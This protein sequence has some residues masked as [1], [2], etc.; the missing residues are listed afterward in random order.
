MLKRFSLVLA[1]AVI[2]AGIAP[3]AQGQ[4]G[5]GGGHGMV[6]NPQTVEVL[7]G[8]IEKME[9]RPSRRGAG[10][11]VGFIL[12]TDKETIMVLLGPSR[13]IDNLPYKP[14]AGDL[15]TVK[16]SR[17]TMGNR[18]MIIAAEVRKGD[19]VM[20]LRDDTGKPVMGPGMKMGQ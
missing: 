19:Q 18:T 7:N 16:G 8:Q 15:V 12:K 14:Q 17:V 4:M 5:G 6:Y 3:V 11:L 9:R 13:F 20:L 10:E 2:V 1:V